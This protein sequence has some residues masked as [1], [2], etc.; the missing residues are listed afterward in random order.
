[1]LMRIV[2]IYGLRKQDSEDNPVVMVYKVLYSTVSQ[3][4]MRSSLYVTKYMD[5]L[6]RHI[7]MKVWRTCACYVQTNKMHTSMSL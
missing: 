3:N 4:D 6:Q 2:M 1:M 5:F 7:Q